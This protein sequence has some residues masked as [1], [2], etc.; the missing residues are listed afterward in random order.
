MAYSAKIMVLQTE[1]IEK[2]EVRQTVIATPT[3]FGRILPID[4]AE[5]CVFSR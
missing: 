1:K 2:G 4:S 5:V 3:L